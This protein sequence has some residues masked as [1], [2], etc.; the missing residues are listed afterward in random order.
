MGDNSSNE[1]LRGK[2]PT[3]E[4]IYQRLVNAI[5]DKR[6]RP[7]QHLNEVKLAESYNIPRSRVRRVLER[8]RDEDVVE[9]RLHHGAFVCR[10]TVEDAKYVFEARRHLE[11]VVI[12][13][14]C[15]RATA[16][17]I[18]SL[19]A[20]LVQERSA[21]EAHRN[22]VNRMAAEFHIL[23]AHI[24]RN[25]VIERMVGLL[26]QRCILVQ[27]VYETKEGVLC[28]T[29][30]HADLVDSLAVGDIGGAQEKMH[31]H[32]DH[33]ISSLDLSEARRSDIDIYDFI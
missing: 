18:E 8:L 22:D 20:L 9:I 23:L 1:K 14:V 2:H 30:E 10:P 3:E 19:R 11:D 33:I 7:G 5:I 32:F 6:L 29:N 13:L 16:E 24:A 28:L 15:E 4:I 31:H 27:S 26:I 25:P 17:D 12:S 21:F